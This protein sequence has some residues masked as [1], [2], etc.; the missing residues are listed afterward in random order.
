[1]AAA[2]KADAER[3]TQIKDLK[4]QATAQSKTATDTATDAAAKKA[5]DS[6]AKAD[7]STAKKTVETA[8]AAL[9]GTE[10]PKGLG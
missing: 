6:A 10:C 3:H 7:V 2:K 5:A 4:D 1:M 9:D 8:Q